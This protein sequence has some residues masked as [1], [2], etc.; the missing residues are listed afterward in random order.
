[1]FRV[2]GYESPAEPTLAHTA[3][4]Q[5]GR[6]QLIGV[7]GSIATNASLQSSA[8]AVQ[9]MLIHTVGGSEIAIAVR[10]Q[11]TPI[12]VLTEIAVSALARSALA[13]ALV[14]V[15]IRNQLATLKRQQQLVYEKT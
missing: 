8:G 11:V 15:Q 7:D 1:M 10:T 12:P 3:L 13:T 5:F 9:S 14:R 6:R 2:G 4:M